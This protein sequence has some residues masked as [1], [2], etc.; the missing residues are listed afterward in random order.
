[1]SVE[2][3]C[4]YLVGPSSTGKTT[5]CRALAAKLKLD[6]ASVISEVARE[7]LKSHNFTRDHVNLLRM[8]EAILEAHLKRESEVLG[9]TSA[10]LLLCDRSAID[11]VA[12]AILGAKNDNDAEERKK[13]LITSA[14]F[15]EALNRY[16]K[17][18]FILFKPVEGWLVDDGVR[19][20]DNKIGCA[21]VFETVLEE[22]DIKFLKMGP[23]MTDLS[24]RVQFAVDAI[25]ES[26]GIILEE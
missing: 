13:I 24:E 2:T 15:Q 11:P 19:S 3:R 25:Q 1:M 7:V 4:I 17:S 26:F 21:E 22:F 12:Y 23:D 16:R 8:Q 20:L 5:L 9:R 14:A 6:K 10:P 18:L